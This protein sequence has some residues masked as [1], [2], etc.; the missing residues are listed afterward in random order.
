MHR[1]QGKTAIVTGAAQGIGRATVEVFVREGAKVYATD[2]TAPSSPYEG[3]V[4]FKRLDVADVS[5][6]SRT[7]EDVLA[8]A[9]VIDV[10][11]NNAGIGG[12]QAALV[13]ETI[14][15]WDSVISVNQTGVFLGMRSV[16]P[17]MIARE[18]GSIINL[19]SIWGISA[20]AFSAAYQASKGA[21]RLLTKHAAI[22][23]AKHNIRVNSVH[24]GIIATPAV[25][26]QFEGAA[27]VIAATPLGRMGHPT[28]L[29]NG[30]LFLAS[31]ES[32]FMTG[33]ELVIDGG[34]TAQ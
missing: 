12:T 27:Q 18:R 9:G 26:S 16:L 25:T 21:I 13:E 34:Y 5:A 10:L 28:E 31:D 11:V 19:S 20:V 32:S 17:H 23:Y 4:T 29:A 24:P 2:I 15:G 30:I 7:V 6:W 3:D 8:E 1:L 33:A 14:E 22:A